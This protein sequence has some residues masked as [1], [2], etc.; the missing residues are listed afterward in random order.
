MNALNEIENNYVKTKSPYN[1][2]P[3]LRELLHKNK[4]DKFKKRGS[5]FN[6]MFKTNVERSAK[7]LSSDVKRFSRKLKYGFEKRSTRE[8]KRI[9]N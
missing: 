3:E 4:A 2:Y 1:D 7:K 8:S 6:K 9:A 5:L